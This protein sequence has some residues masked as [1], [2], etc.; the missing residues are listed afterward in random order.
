MLS[1]LT[2]LRDLEAGDLSL[3]RLYA[4]L[5]ETI[6]AR[7][8]TVQAFKQLALD[9]AAGEAPG[10]ATAPLAGLPFGVKDIYD[11]ADLPAEYGSPIYAGW[12]P[13]ADAAV[14]TM[15]RR[16]GGVVAGKTRTTEFAYLTPTVTTNP[17]DPARTPGGSSSGSA[18]AVAAGFVPFAF[19]TQTAGS[20]IRPG[21]FCGVAAVKPSFRL[22][23]TV[24]IKTFSWHFDTVGLFAAGVADAA[25]VL[26][27]IS[28]RDLRVDGSDPGAPRIGVLRGHLIEHA[29]DDMRNAL[30]RAAT[31][32]A[33]AGAVVVDVRPADI[34]K[35]AQA[36]HQV[37]ND[38]EGSEALAWELE[39]RP[40]ALSPGLR[41]ALERGRDTTPAAYDE[42]RST[43]NLARRRMGDL[44]NG[45]DV[46]L[47]PSAPGVAPE[48]LS[49]TGDPVFNKLWTLLGTPAVNVPGLADPAVLPLG[50]QVVGPFGEDR[51]TLAAA[52]WL[53][54]V[55]ARAS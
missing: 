2:L 46:L 12:R 9:A 48:G 54:G 43:A 50:L 52:A 44:F 5:A 27:A 20:M 7:E 3:D 18:A 6:T 19:G 8:G 17:R 13:K 40:D 39:T 21:A 55:F 35:A 36:A 32:A 10:R 23:P 25:F 37:I 30:D 1:V 47:T 29:S 41:A 53:E 4:G 45:V 26:A 31:L 22:L 42:A 24:G 33:A 51:S 16:A 14:V 28:G 34:F 15:T 38:R 11:T 49:A